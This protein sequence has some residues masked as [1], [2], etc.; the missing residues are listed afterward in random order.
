MEGVNEQPVVA[1]NATLYTHTASVDWGNLFRI[2][3]SVHP[4]PGSRRLST[5]AG[6]S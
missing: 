1:S 2:G 6:G 3:G 5:V 4:G